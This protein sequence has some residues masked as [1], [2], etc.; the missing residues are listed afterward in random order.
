M[1]LRDLRRLGRKEVLSL[2]EG[3]DRG[4]PEWLWP[5]VGALGAGVLVGLSL[6]LLFAPRPGRELREELGRKMQMPIPDESTGRDPAYE[7]HGI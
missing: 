3:G 5:A 6:G 1:E 4:A 2:L 7:A